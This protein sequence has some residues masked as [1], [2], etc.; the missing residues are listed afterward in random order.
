MSQIRAQTQGEKFSAM[1]GGKQLLSF[2]SPCSPVRFST[3]RVQEESHT[4]RQYSGSVHPSYS[5]WAQLGG[6]ECRDAVGPLVAWMQHA[7]TQYCRDTITAPG[8]LVGSASSRQLFQL[9]LCD[10]NNSFIRINQQ[11]LKLSLSCS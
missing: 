11:S 2:P 6:A 7:G 3:S 5:L 9:Q 4:W 1:Q 8:L 10:A